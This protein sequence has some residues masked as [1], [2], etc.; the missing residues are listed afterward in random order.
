MPRAKV[1]EVLASLE[2]K[3]AVQ[4]ART[5]PLQYRPVP[6]KE[7]IEQVRADT[8]HRLDAAEE[9]I[10]EY[11]ARSESNNAIWDIQGRE[12]ILA[13]ATTG[14]SEE[15]CGQADHDR[16]G[17]FGGLLQTDGAPEP[18]PPRR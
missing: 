18:P 7:L 6:P 16:F 3:G 12:Q 5:D 10:T 1:Y 15:R 13:R 2:R 4:V 14:S 11:T 9:A 8:T 17:H